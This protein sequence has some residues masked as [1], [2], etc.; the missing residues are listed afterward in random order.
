MNALNIY[1]LNINN[2]L[3][4]MTQGKKQQYSKYFKQSF[5]INTNK[6]NTKSTNTSFTNH[7]LKQNTTS[8]QLY[9]E[10]HIYGIV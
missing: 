8:T 10:V 7:Y 6:Y 2:T 3:L 5:N 9:I 1:Q 4:F